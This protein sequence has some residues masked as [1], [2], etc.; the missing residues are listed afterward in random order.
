MISIIVPIYN[1]EKHIKSCI[2]SILSSTYKDIEL[3]LIDDGSTDSSGVICDKYA[4]QDARVKV[5]HKANGGQSDARNVGIKAATGDYIMFVDGDDMIHPRMIELLKTGIDSGNYDFA[6]VNRMKIAE[7]DIDGIRSFLDYE[8][9]KPDI[10]ELSQSDFMNRLLAG[11]NVRLCSI[12]VWNKLYVKALIEDL[13]FDSSFGNAEDLEWSARLSLRIKRAVSIDEPLYLYVQHQGSA[14][15][16]GIS[17]EFIK[18]IYVYKRVVDYMPV[19]FRSKA[20]KHLFTYMLLIR[21]YSIHSPYHQEA[22]AVCKEIYNS[23]IYDFLHSDIN[24]LSKLRSIVGYHFPI[25]YN[26]ITRAL[27]VI[28][29]KYY[30]L[31]GRKW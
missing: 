24:W 13:M 29:V 8:I 22:K 7:D 5:I 27:E 17:P 9:E 2:D 28:M 14:M 16:S 31:R 1:I 25:P 23:S 18:S 21:R 10:I 30:R 11:G 6:M 3:L 12:V 15:H 20:L 26:F 19:Q 4:E